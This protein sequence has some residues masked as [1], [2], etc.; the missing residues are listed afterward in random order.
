MR[1]LAAVVIAILTS[2]ASA[3]ANVEVGGVA[4]LHTF[5]EKGALGVVEDMDGPTPAAT[6]LKNSTF[7]GIRL[8]IYFTKAIG[9]EVE[10]GL[11]PTEPRTILFDVYMAA[12]RAQVAYQ[13]R[14]EDA[15]NQLLPFVVAGASMLKIV[16]VGATQNESIV[17]KDTKIAPFIGVGAKYRTGA[18]WGVRLDAR[19]LL[20]QTINRDEGSSFGKKGVSIEV[21]A[22]LSMYRDFG[23]KKPAPKKEEPPP[24]KD[25][26]PDKDGIIGAADK[27]PN[28]PED[29]DGFEDDDGCPDTD[30]DKDGVP[31]ATDK[32]PI[33]PEDKDGFKD[34]DGCPDPDNDEDGVLD[35]NDKCPTEQETKN[36]YKDDDGCPDEI[37]ETL[38]KFTG[39]IQGIN[40]KVSSA[41]LAPGST[42][43]LDKA[44][45]VLNEFTD[46]KLEIQGHTDDQPVRGKKFA[47]NKELSQA[48]ADTVKAYF[49][50]KGIDESRLSAVG[51]GDTQPI[52]DPTGL[53]GGKLN[54]ARAKNRRVEFKLVEGAA[55]AGAGAS[56][57]ETKPETKPETP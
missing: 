3:S 18:G 44:V 6:S 37:P 25:E 57:P 42:A 30:N 40:F 55:G 47:D 46:V 33:E 38:K 16:D 17:K 56:E 1:C 32:C 49:I 35:A 54:Q 27:C 13:L 39:A 48:R 11:V 28:E 4:G 45:A 43:V 34:D 26:D 12:A 36:G 23:Y 20:V 7:F 31:D 52:E 22:L 50:K 8:G 24:Q 19:S 29:K 2:S 9:V 51:Y 41:D 15:S 5:S 10:G 21:E 53:K 14:N